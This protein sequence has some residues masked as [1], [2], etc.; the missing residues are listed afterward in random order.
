[1]RVS[2]ARPALIA[3]VSASMVAL[4]AAQASAFTLETTSFDGPS[5][6]PQVEKVWWDRWGRWHPNY[7]GYGWHYGWHPYWRHYWGYWRP[8]CWRG[9]YGYLHCY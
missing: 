6:A 1:M 8:R 9:Y 3:L 5:V 4:A 7:Y 2:S